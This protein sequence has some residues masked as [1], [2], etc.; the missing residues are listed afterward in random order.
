MSSVAVNQVGYLPSG[1]K[2][3]T[4]VTGATS[5]LPWQLTDGAGRVVAT[6]TT[7][8]RGVDASSGQNVHTVD[9]S[10]HQQAGSGFTLAAIPEWP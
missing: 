1:P 6:G 9:F 10:T 5:A 2:R 7:E 3:A 8:P 4:V